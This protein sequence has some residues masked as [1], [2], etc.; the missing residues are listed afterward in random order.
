LQLSLDGNQGR[1][2]GT[3]PALF[4]PSL[5]NC[6][7]RCVRLKGRVERR[8]RHIRAIQVVAVEALEEEP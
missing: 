2:P 6:L 1:A 8:G 5:V 4:Q 7:G 3:Y